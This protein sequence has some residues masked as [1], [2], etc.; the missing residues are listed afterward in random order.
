VK[1]IAVF[2]K[3]QLGM[4]L[5]FPVNAKKALRKQIFKQIHLPVDIV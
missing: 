3:P 5:H 2:V 1:E 4:N